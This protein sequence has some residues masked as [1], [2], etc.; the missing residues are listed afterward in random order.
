MGSITDEEKRFELSRIIISVMILI[1]FYGRFFVFGNPANL[2][3]GSVCFTQI[4]LIFREYK[5][6]NMIGLI[7]YSILFIFSLSIL[8][9]IT[10]F[11]KNICPNLGVLHLNSP[12]HFLYDYA[13]LSLFT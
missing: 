4:F 8:I 11:L 3:I 13:Y 12:S 2:I 6:I 5:Y 1:T 9:Y 7:V 10:L